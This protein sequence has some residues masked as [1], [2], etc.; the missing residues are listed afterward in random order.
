MVVVV[1]VVTAAS[2]VDVVVFVGSIR[3]RYSA[4]AI[5]SRSTSVYR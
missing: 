3:L 4:S 1:V 2:R 5:P